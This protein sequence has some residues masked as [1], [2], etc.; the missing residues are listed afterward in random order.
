MESR[1][2][3]WATVFSAT[4]L[5][6]MS[7][8]ALVGVGLFGVVFL[9]VSAI[10]NLGLAAPGLAADYRQAIGIAAI[11]IALPMAIRVSLQI[12]MRSKSGG[13]APAAPGS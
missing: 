13:N 5:A 2:S 9:A 10:E 8:L 1:I 7:V 3:H 12:I 6:F 4:V 11:V